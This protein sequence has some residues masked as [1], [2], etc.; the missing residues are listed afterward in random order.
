[1]KKSIIISLIGLT[2]VAAGVVTL[3]YFNSFHIV[4]FSSKQPDMIIDVYKTTDD[5]KL[6]TLGTGKTLSLQNSDYYYV[7]TGE[8]FDSSRHDFKVV[9]STKTIKV[10]SDYSTFYLSSQLVYDSATIH[11]VIGAAYPT[12]FA[13]YDIFDQQLFKQA[14]WYGALLKNKQT[15]PNDVKDSYRIILRKENSVWKIVHVPEIV[16]T[17]TNFPGTPIEILNSVNDLLDS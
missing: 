12:L 11:S 7:A 13:Q 8:K 17:K 6:A 4:T 5:K 16:V 9:G 3:L 10:G 2:V 1:M 14:D 15:N